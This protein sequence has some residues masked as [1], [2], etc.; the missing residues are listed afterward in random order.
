MKILVLTN[1]YPPHHAGTFDNHCQ[2]VTESLRLRGHSIGIRSSACHL[3]CADEGFGIA[4][5]QRADG[6]HRGI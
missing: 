5:Q 2:T 1:L 6:S 4:Q 3:V